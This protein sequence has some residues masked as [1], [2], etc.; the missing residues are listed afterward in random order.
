MAEQTD[1]IYL[2]KTG[3][4]A[5][6]LLISSYFI[7]AATGVVPYQAGHDLALM[8]VGADLAPMV[9]TAFLFT[10]AWLVLIGRQARG[11]AL[12]LA[13]F[14]FWAGYM[15]SFGPS[16]SL[17]FHEFWRDL[18]L[19]G[20]LFLTYSVPTRVPRDA[21][22]AGKP[23]RPHLVRRD[24]SCPLS[25]PMHSANHTGHAAFGQSPDDMAGL[26]NQALETR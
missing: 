7:G 12:L 2:S 15:A 25:A 16:H 3:Q 20:G 8:L 14:V 13:L 17:A 1:G 22:S 4:Q 5:I 11:A 23:K 10:T 6:R 21:T 18:A 9:F 19:I 26:F 24:G